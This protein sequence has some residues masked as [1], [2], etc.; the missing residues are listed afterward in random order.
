M[1][2]GTRRY[3]A[4]YLISS[5]LLIEECKV[6]S[7]KMRFCYLPIALLAGILATR[8]SADS[9]QTKLKSTP[10]SKERSLPSDRNDGAAIG[11]SVGD[12]DRGG[13][14]HPRIMSARQFAEEVLLNAPGYRQYVVIKASRR[15]D[16]LV[17]SNGMPHKYYE[18]MVGKVPMKELLISGPWRTWAF[19]A[20]KYSVYNN[21]DPHEYIVRVMLDYHGA[22][23]VYEILVAAAG[24]STTK[25]LAQKLQ[26]VQ[27]MLWVE[28]QYQP[29]AVYDL[30]RVADVWKDNIFASPQ[31][32]VW[33]RYLELLHKAEYAEDPIGTEVRSL[34]DFIDYSLLLEM[35]L[36]P[37]NV[38]HPKSAQYLQ[39]LESIGLDTSYSP[40]GIV[41][42]LLRGV[43]QS[44]NQFTHLL[45]CQ[46]AKKFWIDYTMNFNKRYPHLEVSLFE[47]LASV[48]SLPKLMTM[49]HATVIGSDEYKSGMTLS[50]FE[51]QF[52]EWKTLKVEK[53]RDIKPDLT[54]IP[55]EDRPVVKAVWLAYLRYC[56]KNTRPVKADFIL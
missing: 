48:I 18:K 53:M 20:S 7:R 52:S 28:K 38:V 46:P 37:K 43:K 27:I 41:S 17:A 21:I 36:F 15:F 13:L 2:S 10:L 23:K 22:K 55:H 16:D 42:M 5:L 39:V 54:T 47:T 31:Y 49:L 44:E 24:E 29:Q 33:T 30:V 26:E 32:A 6:L 3:G 34:H 9:T 56:N 14:L 11:A 12:E 45:L 1:C 51:T 19:F 25:A 50:Y 8:A 4:H 35:P 40:Y